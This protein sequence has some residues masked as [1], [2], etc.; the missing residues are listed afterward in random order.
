[1]LCKELFEKKNSDFFDFFAFFTFLKECSIF[2]RGGDAEDVPAGGLFLTVLTRD[3]KNG[4]ARKSFR[5]PL[6]KAERI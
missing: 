4:S 2:S 5:F 6:E 1:L 3:G